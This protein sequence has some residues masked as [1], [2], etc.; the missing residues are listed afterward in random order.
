MCNSQTQ[1]PTKN[2]PENWTKNSQIRSNKQHAPQPKNNTNNVNV[3][4]YGTCGYTWNQ[5]HEDLLWKQYT[6]IAQI[7]VPYGEIEVY[8]FL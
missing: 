3:P 6:P 7:E 4:K 5:Q 8:Y 2:T 1:Q